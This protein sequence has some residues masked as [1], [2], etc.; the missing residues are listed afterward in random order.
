L[1]A[2]FYLPYPIFLP[3]FFVIFLLAFFFFAK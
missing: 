3:F 1:M 2:R